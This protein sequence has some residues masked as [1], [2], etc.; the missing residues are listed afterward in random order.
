MFVFLALAAVV[1][2]AFVGLALD[3]GLVVHYCQQCQT[4]ADAAAMAA[5][6]GMPDRAV[7]ERMAR[8]VAAVNPT[9]TAARTF[10][11]AVAFHEAGATLPRGREYAPAGGA[12]QVTTRK[13]VSYHFLRAVGLTGL[14]VQRTAIAAKIIEG[15]CIAPMWVSNGTVMS[16]GTEI[17]M[18]QADDPGRDHPVHG[19]FGWLVPQGEAGFVDALKGLLTPAEEE[20]QRV[21]IGDI[22]YS[23][24]GQRVGQWRAALETDADSRLA[25]AAQSPW[26]EDTF[27]SFHPNN[28]RVIIVP[29]VEYVDGN[30]ANAR[31]VIRRFGAFWL[32]DTYTH[33]NDKQ[34]IGRF[35][36]YTTP[37]GNGAGILTTHLI[38]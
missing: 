1:L 35:I 33:G 7:A 27:A 20:T 34:V 29:L 4:T 12:V 2:M 37:G 28:P 19:I 22:V 21:S 9:P 32:E 23:L 11:V 17:D 24:P 25:R 36:D 31:F 6:Q 30:G 18:H 3:M 5:A 26:N 10:T 38:G 16:Y 13:D 15:S 14:T 8:S